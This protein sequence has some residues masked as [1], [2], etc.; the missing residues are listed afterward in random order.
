[1]D[2]FEDFMQRL[3]DVFQYPRESLAAADAGLRDLYSEPDD[4][5]FA[6][7]ATPNAGW[8][9]EFRDGPSPSE[10]GFEETEDRAPAVERLRVA[11]HFAGLFAY[12]HFDETPEPPPGD[13]AGETHVSGLFLVDANRPDRPFVY[14]V[15]PTGASPYWLLPEADSMFDYD[16]LQVRSAFQVKGRNKDDARNYEAKKKLVEERYPRARAFFAKLLGEIGIAPPAEISFDDPEGAQV[17][18]AYHAFLPIADV[19]IARANGDA[20]AALSGDMAGAT[21]CA[22][23][24]Q[25]KKLGV[26][27]TQRW[28]EMVTSRTKA[29]AGS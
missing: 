2:A 29:F 14:Y 22:K 8:L 16:L 5:D 15:G 23:E 20:K 13:P 4:G 11:R 9:A 24:I 10:I 17:F 21:A 19:L 12:A 6:L 28:A 1:M 3:A 7:E 27:L 25:S 18:A 26:A